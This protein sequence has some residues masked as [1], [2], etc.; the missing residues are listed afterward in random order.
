MVETNCVSPFV[1]E[2]LDLVKTI[3]DMKEKEKVMTEDPS[4]SRKVWVFKRDE[5]PY[6]VHEV[7]FPNITPEVFKKFTANYVETIK[8]L[9][10]AQKDAPK[11]T[12][13]VLPEV[14]GRPLIF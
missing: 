8:T 13:E 11:M 4:M 10:A 1:Q 9:M 2:R 14:D 5:D 6:V 3:L 7:T 12:F